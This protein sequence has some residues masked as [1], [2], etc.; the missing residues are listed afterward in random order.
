[1]IGGNALQT[2][3]IRIARNAVLM[4]TVLC[5]SAQHTKLCIL[6][7]RQQPN[8]VCCHVISI[9][10]LLY[11]VASISRLYGSSTGKSFASVV[12]RLPFNGCEIGIPY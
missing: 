10:C 2:L 6:N 8:I 7:E 3:C 12:N 9:N 11:M 1:M 4:Y 5:H